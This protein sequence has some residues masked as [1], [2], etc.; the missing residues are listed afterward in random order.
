MQLMEE[1]DSLMN[2]SPLVQ[3]KRAEGKEEGLR[4]GKEEG[5]AEMLRS[6]ILDLV[7]LR[8]P[9]LGDLVQSRM[10][11]LVRINELNDLFSKL[12]IAS[13][14]QTARLALED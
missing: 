5:S 6:S 11:H 13:D 2:E 4:Q 10:A 7:Q 3:R 1:F 12:V 9:Q 14:E 8:F